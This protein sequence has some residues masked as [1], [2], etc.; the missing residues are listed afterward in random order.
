MGLEVLHINHKDT[1]YK[2][3]KECLFVNDC[4]VSVATNI[5]GN[6]YQLSQN[7]NGNVGWDSEHI[8]QILD[9]KEVLTFET[10]LIQH[11]ESQFITI[12]HPGISLRDV[13]HF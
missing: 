6:I 12:C 9:K 8:S 5:S 11:C 4:K 1:D 10:I 7:Q 2:D 13:V 3:T